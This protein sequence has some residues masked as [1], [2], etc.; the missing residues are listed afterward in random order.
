MHWILPVLGCMPAGVVDWTGGAK[1][2]RDTLFTVGV[3]E[4]AETDDWRI[5]P[6]TR[7]ETREILAAAGGL[8]PL[9]PDEPVAAAATVEDLVE[10][11]LFE[12]P[13]LE[14]TTM[15]ARLAVSELKRQWQ[16][17]VDIEERTEHRAPR[18]PARPAFL[19]EGPQP[20]EARLRGVALHRFLQLLDLARPGDAP[21]L[22]EQCRGMVESGRMTGQDAATVDLESVLWFLGTELGQLLREAPQR[23]GREVA[24]VSGISPEAVDALVRPR[25]HRDLVLVR[26]VA[27]ALVRTERGI[28]LLDY[29]TDRIPADQ[30]EDRAEYYRPQLAH[31]TRALEAAYRTPVVRQTLV[32]LHPR[33]VIDL[34]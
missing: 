1:T 20:D 18:A 30:C 25:D 2:G 10:G 8:K 29:K 28:V 9:P 17:G 24:F 23:V 6:A 32:F 5:P 22:R 19:A 11:T 15:P 3:Y 26:G 14:L 33:R 31:Y 12:Y 7:P 13:G 16:P 4:R 21:D 34:S 27:D